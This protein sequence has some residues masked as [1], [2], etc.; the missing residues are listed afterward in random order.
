[1]KTPKKWEKMVAK[2]K[3]QSVPQIFIG[4][5]LEYHVGGFDDLM[6]H[7]YGRKIGSP[8]RGL[9]WIKYENRDLELESGIAAFETKKFCPCI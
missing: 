6:E 7:D 2:S 3:R 1:M 8:F 5:E 4:S 9:I